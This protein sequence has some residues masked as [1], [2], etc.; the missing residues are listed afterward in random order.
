[1]FRF[2]QSITLGHCR[3]D[4]T[5]LEEKEFGFWGF[6]VAA[7]KPCMFYFKTDS[8]SETE[9]EAQKVQVMPKVNG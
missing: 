8:R 1:M 9:V 4:T 5:H 7:K 6:V 2:Y 3:S